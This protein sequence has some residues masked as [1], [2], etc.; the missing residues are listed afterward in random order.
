M[1][2][3]REVAEERRRVYTRCSAMSADVAEM[4]D[5]RRHAADDDADAR[6]RA[7]RHNVHPC[8]ADATTYHLVARVFVDGLLMT[9]KTASRRVVATSVDATVARAHDVARHATSITPSYDD[10]TACRRL[11]DEHE[12]RPRLMTPSHDDGWGRGVGCSGDTRRRPTRRL[13][14]ADVLRFKM[15]LCRVTFCFYA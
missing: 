10:V 3:S 12:S 4:R 6:A 11:R 13:F 5:I 1:P 2:T 9:P 8:R 14:I 15:P 7:P